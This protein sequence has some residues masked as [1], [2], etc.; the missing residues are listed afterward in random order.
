MVLKQPWAQKRKLWVFEKGIFQF[1]ANFWVAKLKLFSGK[2][3][4]RVQ[5][6]LNQ[7]LVI[8][9]SLE[10][11]FGTTLRPKTRVVSVWKE[12][13][14]VFFKLF[15]LFANFSMKKLKQF[16]GKVRQSIQS[17]LN[18]NLVITSVLENRFEATLS[19]KT[20]VVTV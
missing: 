7:N 18:Q 14:S 16:L 2:V 1:F 10:K 15:Q 3:M 5:N 8:R 4:Q 20:S 17:Y 11:D 6:D 12:H 9:S 13:F 19:S